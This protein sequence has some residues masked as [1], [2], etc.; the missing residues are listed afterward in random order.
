MIVIGTVI[1]G[2]KIY[3]MCGRYCI[4]VSTTAPSPYAVWNISDDWSD[5]YNGRYFN[6]QMDA[7]WEFAS[8][9][10]PWFQDNVNIN[11]IE[12]EEAETAE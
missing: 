4:A 8:L 6:D 1:E 5:V 3:G 9:C 12:D 7:E 2:Y 11:Y 10:F